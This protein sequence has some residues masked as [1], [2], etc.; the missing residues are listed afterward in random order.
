MRG[1]HLGRRLGVRARLSENC[2][3]F[4]MCLVGRLKDV[5]GRVCVR[6]LRCGICQRMLVQLELVAV[7]WI[8]FGDAVLRA[9]A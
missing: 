6:G 4:R 8:R 2:V 9:V 7:L 1:V 3:P 5:F